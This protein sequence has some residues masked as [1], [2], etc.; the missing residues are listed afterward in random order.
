MKVE[1]AVRSTSLLQSQWRGAK[2]H[3]S[4]K[5]ARDHLHGVRQVQ[6]EVPSPLLCRHHLQQRHR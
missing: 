4:A 2:L 5:S 1:L 6:R 3:L